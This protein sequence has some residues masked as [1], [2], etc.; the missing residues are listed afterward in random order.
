MKKLWRPEESRSKTN[1][2]QSKPRGPMPR[3]Y[4][5]GGV[6]LE[7]ATSP[8]KNHACLLIVRVQSLGSSIFTSM[9]PHG[10]KR[11][12]AGQVKQKGRRGI[13][14]LN[15]DAFSFY[16]KGTEKARKARTRAA[17]NG[18]RK[19]PFCPHKVTNEHASG[20][21]TKQGQ[22]SFCPGTEKPA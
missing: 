7:S 8:H 9:P 18:P 5:E 13:S 19:L 14:L 6:Q 2:Q 3:C 17:I 12:K 4:V 15:A 21:R 22:T 10:T 1:T 16:Q 11:G 20:R